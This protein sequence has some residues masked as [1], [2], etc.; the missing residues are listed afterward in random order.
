[1]MQQSE[2]IAAIGAAMATAQGAVEGATKGKVNPAFKSKFARHCS[3]MICRSF[4]SPA[5]WW[6][7]A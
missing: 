1:M 3:T 5:K 7:T 2:S 6:T 4:S